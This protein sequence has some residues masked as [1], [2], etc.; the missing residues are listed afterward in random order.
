[1]TENELN[2]MAAL[3]ITGLKQHTKEWIK[4][5]YRNRNT[6]HVLLTR[7]AKSLSRMSVR[8]IRRPSALLALDGALMKKDGPEH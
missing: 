7:T 8:C 4:D 6:R 5:T 3:A 2:V 1:M